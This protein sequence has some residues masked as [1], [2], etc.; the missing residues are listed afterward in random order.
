M[1]FASTL[2][3]SDHKE[4]KYRAIT[5]AMHQLTDIQRRIIRHLYTLDEAVPALRISNDIDRNYRNVWMAVKELTDLGLVYDA[6]SNPN[7]RG[8]KHYIQLT[9]KGAV[10]AEGFGGLERITS[11]VLANSK[12]SEKVAGLIPTEE[13]RT[14]FYSKMSALTAK[15][16]LFDE[17]GEPLS[18]KSG[19]TLLLWVSGLLS[20]L[21]RMYREGKIKDKKL[22]QDFI[23]QYEKAIS[24]DLKKLADSLD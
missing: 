15:V 23:T 12:D 14:E 6:A 18:N 16:G 8:N 4:Y 21:L 3:S 13:A 11:S 9:A 17:K 5:I 22:L 10:Y 19:P 24:L 1:E 7:K 20:L 2:L